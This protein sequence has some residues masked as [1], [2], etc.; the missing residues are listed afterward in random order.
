MRACIIHT[1]SWI[2]RI[3]L[4]CEK[5]VGSCWLYSRESAESITLSLSRLCERKC[6]IRH[7]D[8]FWSFSRSAD[9]NEWIITVLEN[10]VKREEHKTLKEDSFL[11][12]ERPLTAFH[13]VSILFAAGI[14]LKDEWV[15]R[16]FSFLCLTKMTA[17]CASHKNHTRRFDGFIP[18]L[19]LN[20]RYYRE[21][22]L[23]EAHLQRRGSN[24]G[25][26]PSSTAA[27]R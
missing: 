1:A 14:A 11:P 6:P 16:S 2:Q 3:Y 13:S 27:S 4:W 24:R 5:V 25:V 22:F 17:N 23:N 8:R 7:R 12:V 19:S 20:P 18:S 15:T 9:A 21:H 26:F 10:N